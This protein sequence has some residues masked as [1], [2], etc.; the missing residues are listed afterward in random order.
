[1]RSFDTL[2]MIK[3]GEK[4]LNGDKHLCCIHFAWRAVEAGT[5]SRRVLQEEPLLERLIL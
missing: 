3:K 1:M 4:K 2:L 5:R